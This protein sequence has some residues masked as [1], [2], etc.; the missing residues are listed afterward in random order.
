MMLAVFVE[1]PRDSHKVIASLVRVHVDSA[2]LST[3]DVVKRMQRRDD[4]DNNIKIR[5]LQRFL[6]FVNNEIALHFTVSST[7]YILRYL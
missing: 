6:Y 3:D 4:A 7:I 5:N 1:A 2:C